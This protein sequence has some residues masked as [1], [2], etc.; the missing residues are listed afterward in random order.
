MSSA[1]RSPYVD[2]RAHAL[3]ERYLATFG[4]DAI[5]VPVREI[6]EDLLGLAVEESWALGECSGMLLPAERTILLNAAERA[7]G[8]DDPPLRR[9]RFTIAHEIGHWVC[10]ARGTASPQATYCRAQDLA[11]DAD[12]MLEREANIFA[13]ELLMPESAVRAAWAAAPDLDA[14]AAL[15]GVSRLAAHWRAYSFGLLPDAPG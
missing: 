11:N 10:H 7:A 4:G 9:H 3:R 1:S 2:P 15:L 5:P 13:A 14:C 12:R 6:A 8:P